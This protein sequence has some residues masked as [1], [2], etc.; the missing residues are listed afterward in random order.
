MLDCSRFRYF[1]TFLKS[2]YQ[3]NYKPAFRVHQVKWN[4]IWVRHCLPLRIHDGWRVWNVRVLIETSCRVG[5]I[6]IATW[7]C[8][9]AG[10]PIEIRDVHKAVYQFEAYSQE[11][12]RIVIDT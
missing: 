10:W 6:T 3:S 11:L 4:K 12:I 2:T 1:S 9:N 5:L 8:S 7:P